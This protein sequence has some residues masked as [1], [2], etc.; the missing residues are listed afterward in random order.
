MNEQSLLAA[1]L[2]D[3]DDDAPRLIY[4]DWLDEQGDCDRAEFIRVQCELA[5][6]PNPHNFQRGDDVSNGFRC[7]RCRFCLLARREEESVGGWSALPHNRPAWLSGWFPGGDRR[8]VVDWYRGELGVAAIEGGPDSASRPRG[9][10]R[11][12]FVR[13]VR[14]SAAD[15]LPHG[16]AITAAQPV[17]EVTLTTWPNAAWALNNAPWEAVEVAPDVEPIALAA[18]R[19]CW[20]RVKA[21]HLPPQQL[22]AS[23]DAEVLREFAGHPIYRQP[24]PSPFALSRRQAAR[25]TLTERIPRPR[26]R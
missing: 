14:C 26:P 5:R 6:V 22:V 1:V 3:P 12:G 15:W 9:T 16:D 8:P 18:L 11:R 23:P 10:F 24:Q 17:E 21:W 7:C 13:A 19:K 20:P 2:A 25:R 4:A